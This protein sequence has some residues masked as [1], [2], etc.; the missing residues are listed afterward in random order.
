MKQFLDAIPE[1]PKV[2]GANLASWGA[3]L[4]VVRLSDVS[5]FV[6]IVAGLGSIAVSVSSV[7]WIRK[8]MKFFD[9]RKD[10]SK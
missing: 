4:G 8:Q 3:T 6:T 7:L 10:G 9:Q 2:L 5:T 1:V